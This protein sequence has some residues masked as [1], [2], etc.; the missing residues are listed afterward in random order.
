MQDIEI[1]Q[2]TCIGC[3]RCENMCP[4]VFELNARVKSSVVEEYRTEEEYLGEAP[5]D[6]DCVKVAEEKCPV[7]AITVN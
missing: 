2:N 4:D 5:D 7:D 1:D 6:V 3:G